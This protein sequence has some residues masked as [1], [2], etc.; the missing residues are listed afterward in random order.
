MHLF[1]ESKCITENTY[2]ISNIPKLVAH[3]SIYQISY[4]FLSGYEKKKTKLLAPFLPASGPPTLGG[5]VGPSGPPTVGG[6]VE[7][8]APPAPQEAEGGGGECSGDSSRV[9]DSSGF[10]ISMAGEP[11]D[12]R[13]CDWSKQV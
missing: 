9:S 6:R 1:D 2:Y 12:T 10:N 8:S 7:P 4:A 5:R 11:G 3:G 13:C